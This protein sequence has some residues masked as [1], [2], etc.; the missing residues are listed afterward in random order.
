M[1][2]GAPDRIR[3][4]DLRLRRPTLYPLSYRRAS[5]DHTRSTWT[6]SS[7]PG[8]SAYLV[9]VAI[10]DRQH[11]SGSCGDGCARRIATV[12]MASDYWH[13]PTIERE[14]GRD[15][16]RQPGARLRNDALSE[17]VQP[18]ELAP[19]LVVERSI[20]VAQ[21]DP[22]GAPT[23]LLTSEERSRFGAGGAT[24]QRRSRPSSRD[25]APCR[26][27]RGR[28]PLPMRSPTRGRSARCRCH[29]SR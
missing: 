3:T 10:D 23:R 6:D 21:Q 29:G 18:E 8:S 1:C 27:G 19:F 22:G 7:A 24:S 14:V 25:T 5:H 28:P 20:V 4:C 26:H 11:H 2:T 17:V 15:D 9:A 12:Q 16:D 13:G